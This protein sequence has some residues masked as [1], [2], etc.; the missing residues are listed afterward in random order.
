MVLRISIA[1]AVVAVLM[2]AYVTRP[3]AGWA[4]LAAAA[5]VLAAKQWG[6]GKAAD[7]AERQDRVPSHGR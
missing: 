1:V 7:L 2:A 6:K 3:L 5:L 4:A